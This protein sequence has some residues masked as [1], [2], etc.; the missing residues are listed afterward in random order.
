MAALVNGNPQLR[1]LSSHWLPLPLTTEL[2]AQ[3]TL[4]LLLRHPID[5]ARSVY[6]FE[7]GQTDAVGPSAAQAKQ[8]SFRDFIAWRLEEGRGP[9]LRNY[10]ARY[11]S[12]DFNARNPEALL[13][14]AKTQLDA[15]CF[16]IVERYD[17]S[18]ILFEHALRAVHPEIDLVAPP[19]NVSRQ[20]TSTLEQR[21]SAI[22]DELG[23]LYDRLVAE[24]LLD[25]TLYQYALEGFERRLSAVEDREER[26][27]D[28]Q[29]RKGEPG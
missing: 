2:A 23:S 21:L 1:A 28:M 3:A 10:Q 7:R 12:G 9:V 14:R 29:A 22:A 6:Q 17:E 26:L 13:P 19:Q 25:L 11:L 8:L 15:A 20:G 27:A 4:L 16:G 24:N 18:M 5:R